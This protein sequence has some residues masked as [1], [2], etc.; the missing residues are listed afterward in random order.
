MSAPSTHQSRQAPPGIGR[1]LRRPDRQVLVAA[2]HGRSTRP[3]T[4]IEASAGAACPVSL[5]TIDT[6]AA[7]LS[8]M[9]TAALLVVYVTSRAWPVL[10]LVVADYAMRVLGHR[11]APLGRAAAVVLARLGVPSRP[12]DRAPKAFAWQVGSAM[13]LLSLVLVP[14]A[15][16]AS[17]VVAGVLAAFS[18]LDG[19]GNVC[20]G[21]LAHHHVV[22]PW[23]RRIRRS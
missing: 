22:V 17:L 18:A 19:L 8:A 4:T 16:T 21:C 12:M 15:P 3:G 23:R 2:A 20:V 1:P 11:R 7:R 6:R 10:A 13:A 5:A 14:L 9:A